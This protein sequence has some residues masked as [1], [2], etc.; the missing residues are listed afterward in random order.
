[1]VLIAGSFVSLLAGTYPVLDTAYSQNEY[2][3]NCL[4]PYKNE[5]IKD[6]LDLVS[7]LRVENILYRFFRGL[8]SEE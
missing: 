8:A 6:C 3:L 2:V 7:I 1:M 4:V 5:N